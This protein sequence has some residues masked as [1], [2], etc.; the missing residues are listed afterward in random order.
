M[1]I[2]GQELEAAARASAA[3]DATC[4]DGSWRGAGKEGLVR[5]IPRRLGRGFPFAACMRRL[6]VV[7]WRLEKEEGWG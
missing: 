4:R 2:R 6:L 1:E 7:K 3:A 5:Y